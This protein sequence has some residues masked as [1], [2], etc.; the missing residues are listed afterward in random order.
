MLPKQVFLSHSD[1]DRAFAQKIVTK[2]RQHRIPVWFSKTKIIGAQ[3]WHDEIGKALNRCNWFVIIL[4]PDAVKS[5]WVKNELLFA[6]DHH[7]Y[8][9][10]IVPLLYRRCKFER[11]SWTLPS[12]Q[13]IDFQ[14]STKNGYEELLRV[15][16]LRDKPAKRA[17]P[18]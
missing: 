11:L 14:K 5:V 17:N 9:R 6:L 12:F 15:W 2:L 8:K 16:G 7:R 3:A 18:K 13:I 1:K 10:R 4:S